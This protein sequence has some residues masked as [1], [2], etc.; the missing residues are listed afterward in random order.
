M[1]E[2]LVAHDSTPS[3]LGPSP[4]WRPPRRNGPY[5]ELA[6]GAITRRYVFSRRLSK[7]MSAGNHPDAIRRRNRS[8]GSDKHRRA[9]SRALEASP[10]PSMPG[11]QSPLNRFESLNGQPLA[12]PTLPIVDTGEYMSPRQR[13][14]RMAAP[15]HRHPTSRAGC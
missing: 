9:R 12:T 3:R 6:K 8:I 7:C 5:R 11:E 4:W 13:Q 1:A 2:E 10:R 14:S 15:G